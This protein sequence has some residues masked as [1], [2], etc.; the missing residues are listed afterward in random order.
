MIVVVLGG[1]PSPEAAEG[2]ILKVLPQYLDREGR[3]SL[4][5]S[6]YERDAYQAYLRR[7][8]RLQSTMRFAVQWKAASTGAGPLKLRLE[9]RTS[10]RDAANPYVLEQPVRSRRRFSRWSILKVDPAVYRQVG[11]MIAWRV[12]L[13]GADRQLAEQ[14]SF[15]W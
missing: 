11:D 9:L 1:V 5:P 2:K 4:S 15:L 10:H 7:N 14:K 8:L 3:H 6:L 12:T 13:W